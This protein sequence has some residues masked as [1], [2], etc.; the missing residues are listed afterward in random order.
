MCVESEPVSPR[1]QVLELQ[2][3][4]KKA[5]PAAAFVNGLKGRKLFL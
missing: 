1:A 2:P 5:M 4:A 3:V